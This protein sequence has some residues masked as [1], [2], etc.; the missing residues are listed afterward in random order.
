MVVDLETVAVQG[1]FV[2]F[3]SNVVNN[4]LLRDAGPLI[5]LWLAYIIISYEPLRKRADLAI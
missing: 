1:V 4:D 3:A 5:C 2:L